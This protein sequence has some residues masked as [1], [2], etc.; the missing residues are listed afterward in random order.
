MERWVVSGIYPSQAFF[1][2]KEQQHWVKS[3]KVIQSTPFWGHGGEQ[4]DPMNPFHCPLNQRSQ[5]GE[6]SWKNCPFQRLMNKPSWM[7]PGLQL[8][9]KREEERLLSKPCSDP[10]FDKPTLFLPFPS[11]TSQGC[12]SFYIQKQVRKCCARRRMCSLF[13]QGT[14]CNTK[15]CCC[16][17]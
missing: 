16:A 15:N 11:L 12:K 2:Q 9:W 14:Y 17:P 4:D 1:S 7:Q 10:R 3:P 8:V 6:L 13:C 5:T